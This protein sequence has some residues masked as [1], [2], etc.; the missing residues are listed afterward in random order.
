MPGK[1]KLTEQVQAHRK[2][3]KKHKKGTK[4]AAS[5]STTS[6]TTLVGGAP[7][8][9]RQ[10][11]GL[12]TVP[13]LHEAKR[14]ATKI[15]ALFP[16]LSLKKVGGS[17]KK[18]PD[19]LEELHATL[20]QLCMDCHVFC[21]LI[22]CDGFKP[23][24]SQWFGTKLYS[25]VALSFAQEKMDL[26]RMLR[27]FA[28]QYSVFSNKGG[29]SVIDFIRSGDLESFFE[30]SPKYPNITPLGKSNDDQATDSS[31]SGNS[32]SS[33]ESSDEDESQEGDQQLLAPTTQAAILADRKSVV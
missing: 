25:L 27:D 2:K 16:S 13:K 28:I 11:R 9:P 31:S 24:G 29:G 21:N 14:A 22:L 19:K 8:I 12:N 7:W 30:Q 3:I 5:A 10:Q 4:T 18:K 17:K 33:D 6:S 20:T 1:G 15:L 23:G 26:V 32:S